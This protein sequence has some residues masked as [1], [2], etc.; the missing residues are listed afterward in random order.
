MKPGELVAGRFLLQRLVG[1]GGSSKVYQAFDRATN[2]TIA[3]KVLSLKTELEDHR[4]RSEARILSGLTHP[5]IV[6][7]VAHGETPAHEP[8][9]AMQWL[10]GETLAERLA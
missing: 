8:F 2:D 4:F 3:L 6:R 10:E 7:Y 9:I 5:G 1:E